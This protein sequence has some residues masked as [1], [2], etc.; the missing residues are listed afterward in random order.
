MQAGKDIIHTQYYDADAAAEFEAKLK[1]A[2]RKDLER[3]IANIASTSNSPI[4]FG[5]QTSTPASHN[6]PHPDVLA[7]QIRTGEW[8]WL[9]RLLALTR[10]NCQN[11]KLQQEQIQPRFLR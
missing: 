5:A 2:K 4:V 7:C 8:I 10:R 6:S 1:A 9:K 3:T 11:G